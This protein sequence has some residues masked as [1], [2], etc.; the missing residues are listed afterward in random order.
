M[1]FSPY[2]FYYNHNILELLIFKKYGWQPCI[3]SHPLSLG[4][5]KDFTWKLYKLVVTFN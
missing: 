5:D 3:K 1:S 2:H 4:Q